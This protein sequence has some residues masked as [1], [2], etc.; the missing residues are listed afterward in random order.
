M[1]VRPSANRPVA[2]DLAF[3]LVDFSATPLL[4]LDDDLIVV[5]ASASFCKAFRLDEGGAVGRRL[6]EFGGGDWTVPQLLTL[7]KA[8]ACGFAEVTDYEFDIVRKGRATRHLLLHARRLRYTSAR[9]MLLGLSVCDVTEAHI[10]EQL[11]EDLTLEKAMLR[12]E[13]SDRVASSL[14]TIASVLAQTA[15]DVKSEEARSQ[16]LDTHRRILSVAALQKH[17]PAH[18]PRDGEL[19]LPHAARPGMMLGHDTAAGDVEAALRQELEDQK[20]A[21]ARVRAD[22]QKALNAVEA[23][24]AFLTT[25][26][27][28]LRT[29][30]NAV[31]G[32]SEI[33]MKELFGP[34]A[35]ERYREYAQIIHNS[36]IHLL[37]LVNDLLDL[38]KLDAGKLELH[39]AQVEILKV[40][41]DCV[42]GVETQ[43]N[44][45]HVG[46]S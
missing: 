20:Q 33:L 12:K 44:K 22:R 46:I 32:F 7:L 35:N 19:V 28:E 41:I 45:S 26:S 38:S 9:K 10:T 21:L 13:H 24:G 37:N 29:P 8:A 11:K 4:L 42:R 3:A 1:T 30:L 14:R 5:A 27:H 18:R 39:F 36:G 6:S 40:I 34:I 25:A 23:R 17:L 15:R 16:L 43:A 31:L 2:H